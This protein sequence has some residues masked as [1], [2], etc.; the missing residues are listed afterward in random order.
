MKK[1]CYGE[2][3]GMYMPELLIEPIQH[4]I[5]AWNKAKKIAALSIHCSSY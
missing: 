2:F 5:T 4:L 1:N 3:G